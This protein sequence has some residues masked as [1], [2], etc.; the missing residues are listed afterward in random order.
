MAPSL[1]SVFIARFDD[2]ESRLDLLNDLVESL[3]SQ[4]TLLRT[5]VP[6]VVPQ[7]QPLRDAS[8]AAPA[9]SVAVAPDAPRNRFY[10]VLVG[11]EESVIDGRCVPAGGC[12]LYNRF[13]SYANQVVRAAGY[14]HETRTRLDFDPGAVSQAFPT[15]R[16]AEAYWAEYYGAEEK[17]RAIG[18]DSVVMA[19]A[20]ARRWSGDGDES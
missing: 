18:R 17:L 3:Q 1:D 20:R 6:S 13:S 12:G 19:T 4:L 8:P 9:L 10:C 7:R 5:S 16:E 2:V 14:P 15:L 11:R